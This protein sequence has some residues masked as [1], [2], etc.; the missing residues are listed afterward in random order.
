[1]L[2]LF[3]MSKNLGKSSVNKQRKKI[4]IDQSKI[5]LV[6]CAKLNPRE[7]YKIMTRE[8]KFHAKS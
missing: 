4:K 8:N 6:V 7:I 5:P 3:K 1:M 2:M